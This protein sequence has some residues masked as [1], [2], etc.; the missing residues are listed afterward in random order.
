MNKSK[1]SS[2]HQFVLHMGIE[3]LEDLDI[4]LDEFPLEYADEED[5]IT[6]VGIKRDIIKFLKHLNSQQMGQGEDVN[7]W[8]PMITPFTK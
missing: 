1:N 8:L 7:D 6:L 2:L 4:Q 3:D 5:K